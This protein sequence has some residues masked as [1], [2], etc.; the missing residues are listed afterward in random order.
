[1]K[2]ESNKNLLSINDKKLTIESLNAKNQRFTYK[3]DNQRPLS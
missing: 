3:E 1:M 2:K